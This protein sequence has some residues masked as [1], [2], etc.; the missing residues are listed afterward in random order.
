MRR[1][2]PVLLLLACGPD[3]PT[4]GDGSTSDI[5]GSSSAPSPTNTSGSPATTNTPTNATTSAPDDNTSTTLDPPATTSTTTGEPTLCG[6]A[7]AELRDITG[8]L[9][10]EPGTD[11]QTFACVRRIDGDLEI[12]D[13]ADGDILAHLGN[14]EEVTGGVTIRDN[15]GLTDVPG[16]GCLR[17][18]GALRIQDNGALTSLAGLAGLRNAG[19]LSLQDNGALTSLAGLADLR[20]AGGIYLDG[21]P[22]L[23]ELPAWT[24]EPDNALGGL[25]FIDLP[26]LT[27][28]DVFAG[29]TTTNG[30]F[31]FT[32][33]GCPALTS[34]VGVGDLLRSA[35]PVFVYLR[36][37]ATLTD[38]AG[39]DGV[40]A[41]NNLD[42]LSLPQLASLAELEGTQTIHTLN[43][44]SLP[45]LADLH[46]LE[47]LAETDILALADLPLLTDMSALSALTN[48]AVLSLDR[49]PALPDLS[50]LSS[51]H[52]ISIQL[53]LGSCDDSP[54][55]GLDKLVDLTGLDNLEVALNVVIGNNDDFAGFTGAPK[56]ATVSELHAVHNPSLAPGTLAAWA[57]T[58]DPTPILCESQDLDMCSCFV[59]DP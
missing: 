59:F 32:A 11:P 29:M 6:P 53:S 21:L 42:L 7:C 24:F 49:L 57:A 15:A 54:D 43:A 5:P 48:I 55:A 46:G 30:E 27:D 10:I 51:L 28:L 25:S 56:L 17:S 52:T 41:F 36:D 16:L 8:N 19:S 35:D 9:E 38:L 44:S 18:V 26:A 40:P 34:V 20:R 33:I 31:Y 23:S 22:V 39:L 4:P 2:A 1:L 47:D 37:L 45:K 13:L 3:L 14:L 50:G 58:L 12:H